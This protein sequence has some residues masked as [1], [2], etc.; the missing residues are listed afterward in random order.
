MYTK[1]VE[2]AHHTPAHDAHQDTVDEIVG[3][4]SWLG[5]Q[6][7]INRS[8]LGGHDGYYRYILAD[9]SRRTAGS[10]L[11]IRSR[12]TIYIRQARYM[13]DFRPSRR[14]ERNALDAVL[15]YLRGYVAIYCTRNSVS[16]PWPSPT[17]TEHT[18]G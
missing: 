14:G 13:R 1:D 5:L 3:M 10:Q 12:G 4:C 6:F 7:A 9:R 18:A 16:A 15:A 11:T 17:S 2:A 8:G